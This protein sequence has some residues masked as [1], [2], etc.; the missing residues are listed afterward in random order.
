[1]PVDVRDLDADFYAFSG[2][3]M[4]GPTGIGILYGKRAILDVHA[5]L[6]GRRG[7]DH[8][9]SPSRRPP[10]RHPPSLRGRH[11]GHRRSLGLGAA[12]SGYAKP[13]LDKIAAQEHALLDLRHRGRR[14]G[15]GPRAYRDRQGERRHP[16]LHPRGR[17]SPRHRH[18]AR[19]GRH[20]HPRRPSLRPA[21]M[22][23]FGVPAT[24]RASIG[25]YNDDSD[26]DALA[27]GLRQS[28]GEMFK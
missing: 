21:T 18:P 28:I 22:D 15:A 1:M 3:K 16:V 12:S 10:I 13:G 8:V 5:S 24:A 20:R 25:P 26:L 23:R 14:R 2:H 6:P 11:P 4:F 7:H 19:R 27:K 9:A 17:A